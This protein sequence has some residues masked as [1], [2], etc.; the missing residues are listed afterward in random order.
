M[1]AQESLGVEVVDVQV[2]QID[3]PTDVSVGLPRMNAEQEK[4]AR[5][6]RSGPGTGGGYPRRRRP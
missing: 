6:H 2:K 4:E 3:L 5:E 1:V